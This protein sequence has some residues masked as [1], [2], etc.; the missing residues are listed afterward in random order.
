MKP[1]TVIG[2]MTLILSSGMSLADRTS[3]SPD[4]EE[5]EAAIKECS[6]SADGDRDAMDS[7]MS[8]KGYSKPSGPPPGQQNSETP[9]NP[10]PK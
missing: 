9:P 2:A 3:T 7:C 4:R 5:I 1:K 8:A 10:P 6:A